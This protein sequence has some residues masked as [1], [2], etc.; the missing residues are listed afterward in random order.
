MYIVIGTL[1]FFQRG[2]LVSLD[3]EYEYLYDA[4]GNPKTVKSFY[5]KGGEKLLHKETSF[6]IEYY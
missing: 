1:E 4:Q 6:E 3:I 2:K 5:Y